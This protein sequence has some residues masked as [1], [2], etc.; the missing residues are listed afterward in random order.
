[1]ELEAELRGEFR[2][3]SSETLKNGILAFTFG[4][5]RGGT[6]PGPEPILEKS[7]FQKGA[8]SKY[9]YIPYPYTPITKQPGN[10]R[11][12]IISLTQKKLEIKKVKTQKVSVVRTCNFLVFFSEFSAM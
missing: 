1:M 10:G 3:R 6:P 9:I 12:T 4:F 8:E 7:F 2:A 11:G 5:R